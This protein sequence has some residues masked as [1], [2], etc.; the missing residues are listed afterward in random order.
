MRSNKN[1][2]A[3]KFISVII[4]VKNRE[5]KFL[6]AVKSVRFQVNVQ[7]ELIIIDDGSKIPIHKVDKGG[8]IIK[9]KLFR[10]KISMNAAY[11]RNIGIKNSEASIVAFLDSDDQWEKDHLK[12]GIDSIEKYV[13][14]I[15]PGASFEVLEDAGHWVQFEAPER[16]N[17]ILSRILTEN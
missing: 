5:K 17:A 10:N 9:T 13:R 1:Y 8:A 4:P 6:R 2:K 11:S 7:V 16:V 12:I 15:H 14:D 3:I